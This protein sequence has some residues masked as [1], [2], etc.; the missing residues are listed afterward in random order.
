MSLR[1]NENRPKK[2]S[3]VSGISL[4]KLKNVGKLLKRNNKQQSQ[5]SESNIIFT[6]IYQIQKEF[7]QNELDQRKLT[8]EEIIEMH[9]VRKAEKIKKLNE[10]FYN[11]QN[12]YVCY[13]CNETLE[14][15]CFTKRKVQ[16]D[17]T[18]IVFRPRKKDNETEGALE[19]LEVVINVDSDEIKNEY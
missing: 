3:V 1:N 2:N 11:S 10:S 7:I 15:I 5:S 13:S 6:N 14:C 9:K 12:S 16:F 4:L 19:I 8:Q 17:E 18:V